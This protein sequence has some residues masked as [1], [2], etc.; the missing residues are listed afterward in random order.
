M[1]SDKRYTEIAHC[2]ISRT[3]QLVL[4]SNEEDCLVL[5]KRTVV[6]DEED[7]IKMFFEKGATIIKEDYKD[8]FRIFLENI[9]KTL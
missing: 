1:S 8:G 7:G 9:L 2:N 6:N 5:A 4:S 3:R